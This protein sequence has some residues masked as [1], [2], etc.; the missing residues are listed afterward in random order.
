M[1]KDDVTLKDG[2][3]QGKT[4]RRVE[5]ARNYAIDRSGNVLK[6]HFLPSVIYGVVGFLLLS[7]CAFLSP[8]NHYATALLLIVAAFVTYLYVVFRIAN[9]DW[10]DIRAIFSLVWLLTVGLASLRLLEYQEE[11]QTES[12]LLHG[13]AY[14][15][16]PVGFCFGS[17]VRDKGLTR[18][19][20]LTKHC[21][22]WLAR[23]VS[24]SRL[25]W[26]ALIT[27]LIGLL[28]FIIA[29]LMK[30]TVP[31]FDSDPMAYLKFYTK[32]YVFSVAATSSSSLCYYIIR[33]GNLSAMKNFLLYGCIL[34]STFVFSCSCRI[35]RYFSNFCHHAYYCGILSSR[36]EALG[37]C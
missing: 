5:V 33:K 10:L 7:S 14:V 6:S 8:T 11:W 34:Y 20:I 36:Q 23:S 13:I 3:S 1:R 31:F 22:K 15:L 4:G 2:V 9:R 21:G 25:F 32:F 18:W 17:L 12:W 28:A 37:S 19:N 29:V 35:K 26:L 27:T 16:F 30:G 24:F